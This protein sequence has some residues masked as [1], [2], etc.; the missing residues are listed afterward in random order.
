ML[1]RGGGGIALGDGLIEHRLRDGAGLDQ[2]H[3]ALV[4]EIGL[5]ERRLVVGEIGFLDGRVELDQLLAL[6][7][8]LAAVEEIV[9]DHAA[10]LRRD[11]DAFDGDQRADGAQPV[12]PALPIL[13]ISAVTVAGGGTIFDMK[14]AI[15]FGLKTRLK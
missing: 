11:V 3:L 4:V 15:I 12:D 7:D 2:L 10:E 1:H 13:A 14:S 5:V 8:V 9:G 6:L